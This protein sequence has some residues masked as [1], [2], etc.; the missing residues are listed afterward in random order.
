MKKN[1][2]YSAS[3]IIIILSLMFGYVSCAETNS[4]NNQEQN[5]AG[6]GNTV[7]EEELKNEADRIRDE[8]NNRREEHKVQMEDAIES[9]KLKREEF[10]T[11]MENKKE[12]TKLRM[13]EM[14]TK[15]KE[16]LK[17]VKDENKKVSAEKII[18]TIQSLNIKITDQLS[19]KIDQIENVLVGIE[20][21]IKKAENNGIDV[22]SVKTEAEKAKTAIAD[23]RK[24]ISTQSEKIYEVTITDEA[25]LKA[26]MK[27]LRDTF[28][29]D[30]KAVNENIKLAH[31][32]VKNTATTLA[33]IPKIDEEK[34]IDSA[35]ENNT[36]TTN[37]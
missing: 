25:G 19:Q 9:I 30:I 13:E 24:L 26:E 21:R 31:Q 16:S 11:E 14:K 35:V 18:D 12:E 36:T 3:F 37:N 5:G 8:L 17:V 32:A 15:F 7:S 6:N 4:N 1:I 10:K 23:A 29:K 28:R 2:K 22:S 27:K 20:S 34:A 33:K